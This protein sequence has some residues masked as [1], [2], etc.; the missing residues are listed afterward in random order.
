MLITVDPWYVSRVDD[1][2]E[3]TITLRIHDGK[4]NNHT[5][6]GKVYRYNSWAEQD[7]INKLIDCLLIQVGVLRIS[8][9]V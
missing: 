4:G 9:G 8:L 7:K 6:D 2:T 5:L 1:H 3:R